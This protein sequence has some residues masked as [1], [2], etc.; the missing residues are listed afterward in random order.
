MSITVQFRLRITKDEEIALGPGK[1]ALIEA[2]QRTGS[3]SAAAREHGMSYRRA[4][5]L[6]DSMNRCFKSLIVE[7]AVGGKT[8]G[9]AVVT[10]LG[11]EIATRYRKIETDAA[12]AAA[13]DVKALLKQIR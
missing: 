12:K 9:G 8:G 1:V 13:S 2:I 6:V 10:A 3:I 11:V 5:L 7:T 4:W